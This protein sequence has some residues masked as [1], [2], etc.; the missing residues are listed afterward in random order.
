MHNW[1]LGNNKQKKKKKKKKKISEK[2]LRVLTGD[3]KNEIL[4]PSG[5]P[6]RTL[7]VL[8]VTGSA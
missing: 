7:K 1:Y 5:P 3:A 2:Y 4:G 8:I 6:L